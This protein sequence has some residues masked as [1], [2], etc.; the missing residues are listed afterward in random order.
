M[1]VGG[2]LYGGIDLVKINAGIWINVP[3]F[4]LND[5]KL[6]FTAV[7]ELPREYVEISVLILEGCP[8]EA[9]F[10][11]IRERAKDLNGVS[12]QYT[13]K[14]MVVKMATIMANKH[15]LDLHKLF[16]FLHN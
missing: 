5:K 3:D 2:P 11:F 16:I 6:E 15:N 10:C 12:S 7:E 9:T 4:H 13:V 14:A 8:D 1:E